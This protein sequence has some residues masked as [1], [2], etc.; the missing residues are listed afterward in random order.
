MVSLHGVIPRAA[1][2]SVHSGFR[3]ILHL[4]GLLSSH[5]ALFSTFGVSQPL[6]KPR[7]ITE[8]AVPLS[9]VVSEGLKSGQELLSLF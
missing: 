8:S 5:Q 9:T 4:H 7:G 1:F 3:S 2:T 6:L